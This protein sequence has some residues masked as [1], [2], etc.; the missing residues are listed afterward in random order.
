[1]VHFTQSDPRGLFHSAVRVHAGGMRVTPF[2]HPWLKGYVLLPMAFRGLSRPSSSCGSTGI[3]HEP[4]LTWPYLS[5]PTPLS[6]ILREKKHT[7]SFFTATRPSP[8]SLLL[9]LPFS[10]LCQRSSA[11]RIR[12]CMGRDRVELSTPALSERCSNQ[13]S[14]CSVSGE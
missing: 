5:S 10:Y 2:G 14:Y 9:L 1:M 13:L 8:A 7:S 6:R 11:G 3:R 12:H 4:I